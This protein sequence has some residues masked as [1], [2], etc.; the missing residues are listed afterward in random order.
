MLGLS[1]V[2]STEDHHSLGQHGLGVVAGNHSDCLLVVLSKRL[3]ENLHAWCGVPG[4]GHPAHVGQSNRC[5]GCG[6]SLFGDAVGDH[7]GDAEAPEQGVLGRV[8]SYQECSGRVLEFPDLDECSVGA[9]QLVT[10]SS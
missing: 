2:D 10:D 3:V 9:S 5:C 1:S 8:R 7:H 6:A 4:Y